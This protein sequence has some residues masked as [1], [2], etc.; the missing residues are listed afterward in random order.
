MNPVKIFDIIDLAF[1]ARK[2]NHIFNPLFVGAPGLGKTEIVQQYARS[3]GIR[4]ITMTL[5]SYDPPDFKGFPITEVVNGRQRL[6]FATPSY[7]PDDG[8]GIIILEELNRA[9][10]AI[11]QCVLSLTDARRG[12]DGYRLPP[13]WIVVGCVNPEGAEYD[14]NAMDPALKDRF[15]I[16]NVEFDKK[17]FISYV[18]EANWDS[19]VCNFIESGVWSYVEPG[20][21]KNVP[22]SKYVSP[23]TLSKLNAALKAGFNSEDELLIYTTVLGTNIGR[24]FYSFLHN[25]SPVFYYDLVHN[26][27]S[28][29]EKLKKFSDPANYKSGMIALTIKDITENN[30]IE[31]PMLVSVLEVLPVDQGVVLVR[32]L[33][34]VRKDDTILRRICKNFPKIRDQFKAVVNYKK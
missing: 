10:T 4:E 32:D 15:E 6:T 27:K 17:S 14:V 28:S 20:N 22:G 30:E 16:F 7:W 23:R 19:K 9:P 21:V 26:L 34:L 1:R 13:G 5:S 24:D 8:E 31:D 11:M 29:L 18:K 12:F 3:K 33:E 2:N 25:E